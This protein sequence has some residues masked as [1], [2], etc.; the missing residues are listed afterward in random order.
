MAQDR[1][2]VSLG[3][4]RNMKNFNSLRVDVSYASDAGKDETAEELLERVFSFVDEK[5]NNKFEEV[6]K[7]VG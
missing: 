6:E 3:F 2:E 7:Q 5:F 4:T 1:V